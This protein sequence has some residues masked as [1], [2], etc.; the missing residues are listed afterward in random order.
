[1]AMLSSGSER[2]RIGPGECRTFRPWRPVTNSRVPESLPLGEE[3]A[4]CSRTL[5]TG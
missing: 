5:G 4:A 2:V 1:M 3:E